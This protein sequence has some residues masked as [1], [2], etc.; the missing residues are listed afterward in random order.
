MDLIEAITSRKSIRAYTNEPVKKEIISKILDIARW[1]PSAVNAQPWHVAVV[2]GEIKKN[3]S[4]EIILAKKNK[5]PSNTDYNFYPIKNWPE[6]YKTRRKECGLG[7]LSALKID[8]NNKEKRRIEWEKNYR[9]FDAPVGIFFF[10]EKEL[11]K[12][13][14]TDI[15]MFMQNIMLAAKEY[16]LDSCIQAA[17]AEYPDIVRKNLNIPNSQILLS[18]MALGYPDKEHPVNSYKT[19]REPVSEFSKFFGF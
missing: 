15:G 7:L 14:W 4:N 16:N 19:L 3:I 2:T 18:G 17:T 10:V 11:D 9:F 8:P 6:P 5:V 12:G 13:V 1:A